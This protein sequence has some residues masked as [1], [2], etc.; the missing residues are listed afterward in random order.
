VQKWLC[1]PCELMVLP[2][3][4][5]CGD[6]SD[7]LGFSLMESAPRSTRLPSPPP[8]DPGLGTV[9]VLEVRERFVDGDAIGNVAGLRGAVWRKDGGACA[10]GTMPEM[11][12]PLLPPPLLAYRLLRSDAVSEPRCCGGDT[13]A[14]PEGP[15]DDGE[16]SVVRSPAVAAGK[17]LLKPLLG[18]GDGDGAVAA[19]GGAK[20]GSTAT[21]AGGA[22]CVRTTAGCGGGALNTDPRPLAATGAEAVAGGN[23][24][25]A[26]KPSLAPAASAGGNAAAASKPSLALTLASSVKGSNEFD[27]LLRVSDGEVSAKSRSSDA[28]AVGAAAAAI[29][30]PEL[31]RPRVDLRRPDPR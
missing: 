21:A 15:P 12:L 29:D 14:A 7:F 19:E 24:A 25:A 9:E 23:A 28:A 18:D 26:S 16:R 31:V 10:P 6:G 11:L 27:L 30:A 17:P 2:V 4:P 22:C 13:T 20:K 1:L 3:E 8:D 5:R